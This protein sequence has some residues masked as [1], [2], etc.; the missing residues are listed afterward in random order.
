[1]PKIIPKIIPKI[2]PKVVPKNVPQISKESPKIPPKIIQK[3]IPKVIPKPVQ[4]IVQKPPQKIEPKKVE[5][6]KVEQNK[7]EQKKVEQKKVVVSNVKVQ[8]RVIPKIVPKVEKKI[9]KK[10]EIVKTSSSHSSFL[11]KIKSKTNSDGDLFPSINKENIRILKRTVVFGVSTYCAIVLL[12]PSKNYIPQSVKIINK[13]KNEIKLN[14]EDITDK[15]LKRNKYNPLITIDGL[16]HTP[17]KTQI[18]KPPKKTP[19]NSD[20]KTGFI[21]GFIS[22]FTVI[23]KF[24]YGIGKN[25]ADKILADTPPLGAPRC[26]LRDLFSLP[27]KAKY[28]E[29]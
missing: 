16:P 9:E 19:H 14:I 27:P 20:E 8:P 25:Y 29:M 15:L 7:V 1:M 5:Q 17:Q 13:L 11:T 22:V 28:Y 26:P 6:K 2:V 10:K 18:K 4:K 24:L 23:P 21:A 3:V 12:T